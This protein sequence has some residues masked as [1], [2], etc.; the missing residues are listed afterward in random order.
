[1]SNRQQKCLQW[2]DYV[3]KI[4]SYTLSIRMKSAERDTA[5][6]NCN[7]TFQY[8]ENLECS[9]VCWFPEQ[10]FCTGYFRSKLT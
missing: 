1:M 5:S 4:S 3:E 2:V 9:C 6:N 7:Y 8:N 10:I